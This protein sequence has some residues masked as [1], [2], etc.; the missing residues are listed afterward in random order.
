MGRYIELATKL[1]DKSFL[2]KFRANNF[3]RRL[4]ANFSTQT[5]EV[6]T[7]LHTSFLTQPN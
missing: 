3:D 1:R 7:P 5:D 6:V 2:Y 4:L